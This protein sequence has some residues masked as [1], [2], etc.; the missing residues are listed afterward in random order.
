MSKPCFARTKCLT[1]QRN[2]FWPNETD[3]TWNE[4]SFEPF[5]PAT[6]QISCSSMQK[7]ST[8]M[9]EY[10]DRKSRE[11]SP[12]LNKASKMWYSAP[13]DMDRYNRDI[14]RVFLRIFRKNIPKTFPLF[15]NPNH[16]QQNRAAY[17][18]AMA[19][20]GGL[21]CTVSGSA[22]VA[23]SM[24]N[25]ARRLALASVRYFAPG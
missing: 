1:R 7:L 6:S 12:I 8:T 23:K 11:S 10:F 4:Y 25:D 5:P 14:V 17:T 16:S 2:Q 13:P 20:T 19:A 15:E 22:E 3:L 18:L 9:Q 24:Y 21:F